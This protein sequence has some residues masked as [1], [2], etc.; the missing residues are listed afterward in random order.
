MQVFDQEHQLLMALVMVKQR[1][2][3]TTSRSLGIDDD[4]DNEVDSRTCEDTS[5]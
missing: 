3:T 1:Y 4:D 2:L 5:S